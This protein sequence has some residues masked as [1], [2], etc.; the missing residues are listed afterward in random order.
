MANSKELPIVPSTEGA[1]WERND[2]SD[3]YY[4]KGNREYGVIRQGLQTIVDRVAKQHPF[5]KELKVLE[6][7]SEVNLSDDLEYDNRFYLTVDDTNKTSVISNGDTTYRKCNNSRTDL[8][9]KPMDHFTEHA[10]FCVLG[11]LRQ[12]GIMT[13]GEAGSMLLNAWCISDY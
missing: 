3:L 5:A 12:L 6:M 8:N 11:E 7:E 10:F 13:D 2:Y 9:F 4:N 1:T